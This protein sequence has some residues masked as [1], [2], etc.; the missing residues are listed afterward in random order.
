[1][2]TSA[3]PAHIPFL[4]LACVGAFQAAPALADDATEAEAPAIIV[5]GER[6][7]TEVGSPK[8]TAPLLDT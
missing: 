1:M 6:V 2:K 7:D 8:A 3:V 5:S 4:A